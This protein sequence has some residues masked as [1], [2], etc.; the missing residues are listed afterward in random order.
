MSASGSVSPSAMLETP[1]CVPSSSSPSSIS[2]RSSDDSAE[3]ARVLSAI[4]EVEASL[5]PHLDMHGRW[6]QGRWVRVFCRLPNFLG[7]CTL[8]EMKQYGRILRGC[9][10]PTYVVEES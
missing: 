7:D 5:W 1:A 4:R 10:H 3:R 6:K 2:S 8:A 9:L